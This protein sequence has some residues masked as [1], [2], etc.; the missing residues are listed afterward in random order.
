ML[1][2]FKIC[3]LDL[4]ITLF[5]PYIILLRS[6]ICCPDLKDAVWLKKYAV[7]IYISMRATLESFYIHLF[8]LAGWLCYNKQLHPSRLLLG[9]GSGQ[10]TTTR[11]QLF[12][13]AQS[14]W[15]FGETLSLLWDTSRGSSSL[16]R[17]L[18][19]HIGPP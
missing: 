16:F 14:P 4:K 10:E 17:T 18:W 11:Y 8:R 6:K 12:V 9:V 13:T 5:R 7:R 3:C 1:C 15:Q 19:G 2:G